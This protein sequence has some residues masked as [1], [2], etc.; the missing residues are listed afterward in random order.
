M[1]EKLQEVTTFYEFAKTRNKMYKC[2]CVE[3]KIKLHRGCSDETNPFCEYNCLRGNNSKICFL[4]MY[5]M[6]IICIL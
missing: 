5:V 4:K 6:Y 3:N 2:A 1:V